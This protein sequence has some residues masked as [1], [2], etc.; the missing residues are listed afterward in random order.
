MF[1]SFPSDWFINQRQYNEIIM[2]MYLKKKKNVLIRLP[3]HEMAMLYDS[4]HHNADRVSW[5]RLH[6]N[7]NCS[8]SDWS[9]MT[10]KQS[11]QYTVYSLF[12]RLPVREKNHL[13]KRNRI[14]CQRSEKKRSKTHKRLKRTLFNGTQQLSLPPASQHQTDMS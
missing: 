2:A 8:L 4:K 6:Y 14:D 3:V 1:R 7:W 12:V 11:W 10:T 5:Q 9:S 13:K